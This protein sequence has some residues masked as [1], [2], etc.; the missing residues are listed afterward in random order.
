MSRQV[1]TTL[2][3]AA[4]KN[5]SVAATLEWLLD[6]ELEARKQRA[7][8]R[9]FKCSRLQAQPSIDAFHFQHHKTRQPAKPRILRLLDLDFLAKGTNLVLIGNPGVGQTF[10]AKIIAWRACR[11]NQRVLFTSAMDMLN[12]LLASQV[13]HSLVR[14]L[15]TYTEPSLLV[16]DELGYLALDQ[17]TSN[18]FYQVI[19]TRHSQKRSTI[20]TTNT[21]FSDWGNILFN[22]TIATAIADRLVENSEVFLLG[23]ESLRKPK[24]PNPPAEKS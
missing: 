1:E 7:I 2:T 12:H 5:L 17:H 19:S 20:I 13:D 18:L 21:P 10:L 8:D 24:N 23:G 6:M 14:K 4:A 22:T 11:A 3:E 16:C 9:R 15:R